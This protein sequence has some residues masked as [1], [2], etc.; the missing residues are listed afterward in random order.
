MRIFL[1]VFLLMPA[2]LV[3]Q[4][5]LPLTGT[6]FPDAIVGSVLTYDIETL[7]E[8]NEGADLF[9][10]FG[11]KSLMVQEITWKAEKIKV[12]VYQMNSAEGAFGIHTLSLV[13]CLQRDTLSPFDCNSPYQY[14][15]PYGNLY[16]SVTSET[17][18]GIARAMY[19]PVAGAIM[20]KNPQRLIELPEPFSQPRLKNEQKNLVYIQGLT[21]LQNSFFPWQELFLGV[22]F[23]M[24]AIFLS[25][26][27]N[28][29]YFA[30]IRFETPADMVRF[31]TLAGLMQ[32]G[33]PIPNT[34]NNDGLYR[35]FQQLD[36]GTIYFLQSQ[37][38][39]PIT[40]VIA[41]EK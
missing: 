12:E 26:S 7:P 38:P 2:L 40:W 39:L 4:P 41:P 17:G 19:L 23:G 20:Q 29:L 6:D 16:I 35:E 37:V 33:I 32:D 36:N 18:S 27:D 24:Y 5:V 15:L 31:L 28:E 3:A 34:N 10:E 22:R 13:K 1:F 11:F 30:R 8:Y 25:N 14:Q 21:G 9:S